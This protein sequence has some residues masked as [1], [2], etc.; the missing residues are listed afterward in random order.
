[1]TSDESDHGEPSAFPSRKAIFATAK[2]TVK[3]AL[4]AGTKS[5]VHSGM[6]IEAERTKMSSAA[7]A[8]P[9]TSGIRSNSSLFPWSAALCT[10][11]SA[12]R[13]DSDRGESSASTLGAN[14]TSIATRATTCATTVRTGSLSPRM[15]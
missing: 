11:A 3:S 6:R 5:M 1:M 15:K 8:M 14:M 12:A 7:C 2:A 4:S 9:V 10:S 13:G